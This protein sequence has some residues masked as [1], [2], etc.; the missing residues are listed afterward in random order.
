M[1]AKDQLIV[2]AD[3]VEEAREEAAAKLSSTQRLVSEKILAGE[4]PVSIQATDDAPEGAF[5]ELQKKIPTGAILLSKEVVNGPGQR[6]VDV[7][8]A[9][10]SQ[11]V[12]SDRLRLKNHEAIKDAQLVKEGNRGFLG[13]GKK[14]PVFRVMISQK[15]RVEISYQEKV[16]VRF[17]VRQRSLFE[18]VRSDDIALLKLL[19]ESGAEIDERDDG[20]YTP[21]M[22]AAVSHHPE[23]ISFLLSKGADV[24]A[25]TSWGATALTRAAQDGDANVVTLLLSN[26]ADV[27]AREYDGY[28]S[29]SRA[30]M[31]GHSQIVR[32]LLAKGADTSVSTKHGHTALTLAQENRHHDI[33]AILKK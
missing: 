17:T 32:M 10:K 13:F 5:A 19:A 9:D 15:T 24:N 6:E 20:G 25:A 23:M 8:A 22:L 7:E 28:T 30:S 33:V 14:L 1:A 18:A 11:A 21:L 26:G 27:N 29:L 4:R 12:G 2:E 31:N 3:S 16:K